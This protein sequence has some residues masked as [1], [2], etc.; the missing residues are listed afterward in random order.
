MIRLLFIAALSVITALGLCSASFGVENKA[1][2]EPG[3]DLAYGAYQRGDYRAAMAEAQKRLSSNPKDTAALTLIG[4]LYAEGT[5][6]PI[7]R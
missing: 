6:V 2:A 7:D 5:G 4:Q 3:V 1:A